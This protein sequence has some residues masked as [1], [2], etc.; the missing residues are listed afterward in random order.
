MRKRIALLKHFVRNLARHVWD[1]ASR[2]FWSA[3]SSQRVAF[4]HDHRNKQISSDEL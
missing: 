4:D 3:H 1:F 2:S